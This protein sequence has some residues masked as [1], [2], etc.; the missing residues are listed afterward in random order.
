MDGSLLKV[1]QNQSPLTDPNSTMPL[2]S[3]VLRPAITY[4]V[5]N[6]MLVTTAVSIKLLSTSVNATMLS[7][8]LKNVNTRTSVIT[9]HGVSML[10][11][12]TSSRKSICLGGRTVVEA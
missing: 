5:Q 1:M 4:H 8:V 2:V 10:K 12:W 11:K 7:T 6:N 3:K 9:E